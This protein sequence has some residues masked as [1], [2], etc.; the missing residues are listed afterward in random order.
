MSAKNPSYID[1]YNF[2]PS[3]VKAGID[4]R[5]F[6]RRQENSNEFMII[7]DYPVQRRFKIENQLTSEFILTEIEHVKN[8]QLFDKT[9]KPYPDR[10]LYYNILIHDLND[11][12]KLHQ[13]WVEKNN[14]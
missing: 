2:I 1:L 14:P 8:Q 6:K 3:F 13:Y 11:L 4:I 7:G 12:H 9:V 10:N 5:F